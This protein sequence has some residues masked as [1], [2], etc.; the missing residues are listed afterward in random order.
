[1]K[2]YWRELLLLLI[3]LA[4]FVG[5][6]LPEPIH[7]SLAYHNFPDQRSWLGV[8]NFLNVA[9]NLPFLFVGVVGLFFCLK[10]RPA[11]A[12]WSWAIFFLG[13][14]VVALGSGFYHWSPS[15]ET[16]VWDRLPMTIGFMGLLVGL[17]TEH[18]SK[19]LEKTLLIPALLLGFAS[20]MYWDYAD[21]LRFYY[22]VQL[23]PLLTIPVVLL[24]FP[25]RY[26]HQRYLMFALISYLVAKFFEAYDAEIYTFTRQVVSGHSIKHASAAIGS[27]FVYLMLRQR[28]PR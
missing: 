10:S 17:L 14:A 2:D 24:L 6:M 4:S 22:W 23:I 9:S 5:M 21:D 18:V 16:L 3:V 28:L 27:Y 1:M 20:V 8:P 11:E 25:G 15:N 26:T 12:P 13:V 7:Q 19:R